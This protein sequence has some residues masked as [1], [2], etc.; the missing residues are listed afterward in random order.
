[1][2]DAWDVVRDLHFLLATDDQ[3]HDDL[4]YVCDLLTDD[5]NPPTAVNASMEDVAEKDDAEVKDKGNVEMDDVEE[6]DSGNVEKDDGVEKDDDGASSTSSETS[7]KKTGLK[8]SRAGRKGPAA[9]TTAASRSSGRSKQQREIHALRHQVDLLKDQLI[10]A[11]RAAGNPAGMSAWEGAARDQLYARSK[12]LQENEELRAAVHDQATLIAHMTRLLRKKPRLTLDIHSEAWRTYKL[13]AQASLRVAAVHAIADR[14]YSQLQTEFIKAGLYNRT[15]DVLRSQPLQGP[16]GRAMVDRAYHVKLAAPFRR[17]G[18]AAWTVFN[19]QYQMPLPEG[20]SETFEAL[21]DRTIYRALTTTRGTVS[22]HSNF[23]FK[24]YVEPEREVFVWRSVLEDAL[25]PR[26]TQ[27]KVQD[28]W[29]WLVVA[30]EDDDMSCRLT[31]LVHLVPEPVREDRECTL[32]EMFATSTRIAHKY[33][34]VHPADVPGMFPGGPIRED[35]EPRE[36]PFAKQTFVEH[37]KRLE[38][39][40]KHVINDVVDEF[41][42]SSRRG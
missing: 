12:S 8:R 28:E 3:L 29:G 4:T 22:A 25:V 33:A 17:V 34:F 9:A 40:L 38:T 39:S 23:V 5:V 7:Q 18:S 2:D 20:A 6:K 16:D 15:D 21:D 24:Y 26:M 27:G 14:Q 41:Q 30:P 31:L 42:R 19:G 13:A 11:K 32:E 10:E 37:G 35:A 1:M 36:L